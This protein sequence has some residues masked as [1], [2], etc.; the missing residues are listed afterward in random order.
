MATLAS[1]ISQPP[2][3]IMKPSKSLKNFILFMAQPSFDLY[4]S[5]RTLPF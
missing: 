1:L 3:G 5:N 4:G 2:A